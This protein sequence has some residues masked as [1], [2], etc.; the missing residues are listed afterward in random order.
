MTQLP[1]TVTVIPGIGS[2]TEA[3]MIVVAT[4]AVSRSGSEVV[5]PKVPAA[6]N[7]TP[8]TITAAQY[9]LADLCIHFL[10]MDW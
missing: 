7:K 5:K 2:F 3:N 6:R 8:A 10:S 9:S 1:A 4:H